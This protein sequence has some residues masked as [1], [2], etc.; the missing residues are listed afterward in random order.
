[1]APRRPAPESATR[2]DRQADSAPAPP[3]SPADER[4]PYGEGDP[5][6]EEEPVAARLR[7]RVSGNGTRVN[8]KRVEER[9][10]VNEDVIALGASWLRTADP[11]QKAQALLAR[12][13]D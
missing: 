7:D 12:M 9:L 4:D 3:G 1:M 5:L 6:P 13:Q 10:V 11:Y 2:G 8:G